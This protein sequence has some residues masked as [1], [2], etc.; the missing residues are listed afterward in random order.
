M[1]EETVI[2]LMAGL[3]RLV[4]GPGRIYATGGARTL[5]FGWRKT[6]IDV[7]IER[8]PLTAGI[9]YALARLKETLDMKVKL[10]LFEAIG[11]QYSED[12][13]SR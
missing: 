5:L 9:F 12:T 11:R 3:G 1:H 8:E 10:A 4:E 6:P 13:R 7:D 2:Q